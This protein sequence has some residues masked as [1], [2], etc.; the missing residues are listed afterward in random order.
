MLA[1]AD[2]LGE[3]EV[4]RKVRGV[5]IVSRNMLRLANCRSSFRRL[6]RQ[7]ALR[8]QVKS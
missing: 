1:G 3:R 7:S 2:S 4:K 6:N 8:L 5:K